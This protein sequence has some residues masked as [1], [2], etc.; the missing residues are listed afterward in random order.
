MLQPAQAVELVEAKPRHRARGG[1]ILSLKMRDCGYLRVGEVATAA[2][3]HRATVYR[4]IHDGVVD[5]VDFR[6]A[7]YVKWG[8]VVKHLGELACILGLTAS[9]VPDGSTP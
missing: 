7:Y 5:F 2:G 8:S 9:R 4:W 6:G 3:V 1:S